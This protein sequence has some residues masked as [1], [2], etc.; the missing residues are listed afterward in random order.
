MIRVRYRSLALLLTLPG[1]VPA[2]A[3]SDSVP[4]PS[5][6]V[7][8]A[9]Q[10]RRGQAVF[11]EVCANCHAPDQFTAPTFLNSWAGQPAYTLF[12]LVRTTM[13]FDSPGR[14]RREEYADVVAYLLKLNRLPPGER[15]LPS[16]DAALRQVRV[17]AP[18]A[19]RPDTTP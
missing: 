12:T 19:A 16:E 7:Y 10:A 15:E 6:G 11:T 18:P 9:A 8:T 4:S 14:L 17:P 13:P 5:A 1:F 3:Q 2:A